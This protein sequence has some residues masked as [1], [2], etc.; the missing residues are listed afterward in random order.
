MSEIYTWDKRYQGHLHSAFFSGYALT[1][2]PGGLYSDR[3]GSKNVLLLSFLTMG[4]FIF[5]TPLCASLSSKMGFLLIANRILMGGAEGVQGA[6][7]LS[8]V[9]EWFPSNEAS[10]VLASIHGG[11]FTGSVVAF[12]VA[13]SI[14]T[15]FGWQSIWYICGACIFLWCFTWWLGVTSFPQDHPSMTE[16][17]LLVIQ[18]TTLPPPPPPSSSPQS[19]ARKRPDAIPLFTLLTCPAT[20]AIVASSFCHDWAWYAAISW[21]PTYFVES[22][23]LSVQVAALYSAF[24]FL[25]QLVTSIAAGRLGDAM[26][27]GASYD[28]VLIVR[29]MFSTVGFCG[30]G[31]FFMASALTTSPIRSVVAMCLAF[32]FDGLHVAGYVINPLD[33]A[34]RNSGQIK[35]LADTFGCAAGFLANVSVG[36]MAH[37]SSVAGVS[38]FTSSFM[39]LSSLQIVGALI[40]VTMSGA[41]PRYHGFV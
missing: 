22:H 25:V 23:Q 41:D 1:G 36:M 34:P 5:L 18:E 38:P 37:A 31:V 3:V 29:K 13:P 20:L 6:S 32:A 39:L 9:S 17:E 30:A 2:L 27:E 12:I 24:P 11:M 33:I 10:T 4:I 19:E 21:L 15:C 16:A 28:Q 8:M 40:F 26:V 14:I 7:M 35:G